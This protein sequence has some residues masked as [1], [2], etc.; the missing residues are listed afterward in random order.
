[1]LNKIGSHSAGTQ[2]FLVTSPE[3]VKDVVSIIKET[4]EKDPTKEIVLGLDCE[5]L[6]VS[7]ELS[8]LQVS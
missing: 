3:Q 2:I 6:H 7:K 5:G 8:L 1:M 4:A